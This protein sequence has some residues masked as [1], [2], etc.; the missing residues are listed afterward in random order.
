DNIIYQYMGDLDEAGQMVLLAPGADAEL[1]RNYN[2]R[3]R[4]GKREIRPVPLVKIPL[5]M[6]EE[7]VRYM[8]KL[9]L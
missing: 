2:L 5:K 9:I 4:S 3:V 6:D 8:Q 1:I 7:I